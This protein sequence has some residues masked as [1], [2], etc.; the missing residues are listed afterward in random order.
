MDFEEI[1]KMAYKNQYL[2]NNSSI[3]EQLMWYKM[4]EIYSDYANSNLSFEDSQ[5]K[6]NKLNSYYKQQIRLQNFYKDLKDERYARIKE[7][8]EMLKEILKSEKEKIPEKELMEK[9]IDYVVKITGIV[10]IR[11][12]YQ[13]NYEVK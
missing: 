9:L 13:K 6:K 12:E 10:P 7:S 1:S 8:E 3:L 4:K 2:G 11:T 5:N